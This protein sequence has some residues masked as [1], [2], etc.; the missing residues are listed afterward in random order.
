MF[1]LS[2]FRSAFIIDI[3]FTVDLKIGFHPDVLWQYFLEKEREEFEPT[4][5]ITEDRFYEKGNSN[6]WRLGKYCVKHLK[7]NGDSKH[8]VKYYNKFMYFLMVGADGTSNI[9]C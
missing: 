1:Q 5:Y 7:C 3:D 9:G 4:N 2:Q 6:I 8:E